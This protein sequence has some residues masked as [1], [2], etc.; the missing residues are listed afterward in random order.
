MV[1]VVLVALIKR[2]GIEAAAA[3]GD[4]WMQAVVEL[5]RETAGLGPAIYCVLGL[6]PPLPDFPNPAKLWAYLGLAVVDGKAVRVPMPPP[7]NNPRG[8]AGMHFSRRI[9]AYATRR[10]V[11]PIIRNMESAHRVL[12]DERRL[13]TAKTHPEWAE[14]RNKKGVLTPA[15]HYHSDAIRYV[16]KR[17]W[18]DV[19]NAAHGCH[20]RSDTQFYSAPE[21]VTV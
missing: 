3:N 18:R 11:E 8:P 14:E 1:F 21:A 10:I 13:H 12:Y 19:W 20:P 15:G 9:R 5:V 7:P 17:I 4:P 6:I 2:C 16:A